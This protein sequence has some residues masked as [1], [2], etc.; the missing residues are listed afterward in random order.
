MLLIGVAVVAVI[1]TVALFAWLQQRGPAPV[2]ASAAAS[3]IATPAASFAAP[4]LPTPT[5]VTPTSASTAES[6]AALDPAPVRPAVADSPTLASPAPGAAPAHVERA[7]V[8]APP[9]VEAK[10][11]HPPD[12]ASVAPT[13]IPV[14]RATV[15]GERAS[16]VASA[17]PRP[18]R[19]RRELPAP[20]RAD[21]TA[22]PPPAAPRAPTVSARCS[23][24]LQKAS[25]E[26]LTATEAAYLK[27]E[28][29]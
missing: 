11:D 17:P 15:D 21:N 4:S 18:A 10:I 22:V 3:A 19:P 20:V 25:L 9:T 27:R 5:A 7:P 13:A 24:I 12:A 28:C 23:D 6:P 2:D 14:E 8:E 26:P 1:A 16:G 29:R